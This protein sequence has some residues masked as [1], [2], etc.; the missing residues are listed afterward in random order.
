[1][2]HSNDAF[3]LGVLLQFV[4]DTLNSSN[5]VREC[6]IWTWA[7][8]AWNGVRSYAN[9]GKLILREDFVGYDVSCESCVVGC[10]ICTKSGEREIVELLVAVVQHCQMAIIG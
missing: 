8:D 5:G 7:G 1:M 4:N 6:R 9:N 10:Y 2:G 3:D